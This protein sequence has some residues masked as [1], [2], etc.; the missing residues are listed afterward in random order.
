M[1]K[2]FIGEIARELKIH[3]QTIREYE[4]RGLIS[5]QR[6]PKNMRYFSRR[7]VHRLMTII[8]LTSELRINISGVRLILSLAEKLG[9]NDDELLDYIHDHI[10]EYL[11]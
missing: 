10:N 5:P 9:L 7:D 6:T 11:D 8:T 3:E 1:K 2:K 4:R